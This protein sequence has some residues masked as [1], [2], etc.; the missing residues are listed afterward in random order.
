MM[1]YRGIFIAEVEN[2]DHKTPA[3]KMQFELR[4]EGT[5]PSLLLEKPSELTPE[6]YP[7]L[8]FPRT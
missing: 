2:G 6:G 1:R 3:G 7:H 5:L 4:G 8:I